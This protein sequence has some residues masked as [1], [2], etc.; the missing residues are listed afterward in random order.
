MDMKQHSF[1]HNGRETDNGMTS[2]A[3]QQILNMQEQTTTAEEWLC[4][5]VPAEVVSTRE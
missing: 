2:I 1:L 5:N 3:R 4:K